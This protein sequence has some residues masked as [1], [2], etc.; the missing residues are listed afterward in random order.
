MRPEQGTLISRAQAIAAALELLTD[1]PVII[2]NGF[3]SREAFKIADRPTHFYMIGSMGMAPAIGLGVALAKPNK[4]VVIFDGDGNVLMGL[5]TL[6]TVG[7]L[8]P[9]NFVHIVFDNEV[10]GSTGNQ[11]TI[12]NVVRLD[13][14]AKAAG[15][16]N[17][18]RVREREDLVYEFKDML[19]KD[20]PSFLLVKVNEMAE[21]AGRVMLEPPEITRR[22]MKAIA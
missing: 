9:K 3:P 5:G 16:V 22:F 21:D 13:L 4:K 20:G 19:E 15:Y 10:Y 17:V 12:S 8:R 6:A 7:A 11:P 2:C 14:V 18:E 1:Q